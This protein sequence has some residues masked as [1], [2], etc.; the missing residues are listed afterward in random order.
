MSGREGIYLEFPTVTICLDVEE[1]ESYVSFLI[2]HGTPHGTLRYYGLAD[3][4]HVEG[5]K[6]SAFQSVAEEQRFVEV[7]KKRI[8]DHRK[9]FSPD[10]RGDQIVSHICSFLNEFVKRLA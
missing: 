4:S 6:R 5:K 10:E 1:H 9:L 3:Y 7:L 2:S 8:R